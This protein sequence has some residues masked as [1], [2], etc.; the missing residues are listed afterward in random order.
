VLLRIDILNGL[1]NTRSYD[2]ML[3]FAKESAERSRVLIGPAR[4]NHGVM[5][6]ML[7]RAYRATGDRVKPAELRREALEIMRKNYPEQHSKV[8][9]ARVALAEHLT[10]SGQVEA[11]YA[12]VD[13]A[14]KVATGNPSFKRNLPWLQA[15]HASST[16]NIGRHADALRLYARAIEALTSLQG[17]DHP[18]TLSPRG[19]LVELLIEA[20]QVDTA[21][22][23]LEGIMD[24][25]ARSAKPG[26]K[27]PARMRGELRALVALI[28]GKPRDAEQLARQAHAELVEL[29]A[30]TDERRGVITNLAAAL[31]AQERYAEAHAVIEPAFT[32]IPKGEREDLAALA[33]LELAKCEAG[34]GRRDDA[35]A[36]AVRLSEVLARWPGQPRARREVAALLEALQP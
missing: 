25:L 13:D 26:D 24:A 21:E 27:R 17:R 3:A 22:R 15:R 28:R 19:R 31:S 20:E 29:G 10:A 16:W 4:P 33:A 36:R 5:L 12:E 11:A 32:A 18:Q 23:E 2:D 7:A 14:L 9:M 30:N 34:L 35:R 1:E 8:V 6:D